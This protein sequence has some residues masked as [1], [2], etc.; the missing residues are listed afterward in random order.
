MATD[1]QQFFQLLECLMSLDNNVRQQAEVKNLL[2]TC[3]FIL[4]LH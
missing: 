4:S 2:F 1:E 3:C